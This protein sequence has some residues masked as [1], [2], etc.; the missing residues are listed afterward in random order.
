[1]QAIDGG[2]GYDVYLLDI[3]MPHLNGIDVA[4][5]V[6]ERGET[7]EILFLTTS[8]EYAVEAFGVK[9]SGYLI[10]PVQK[11]DF[12]KEMLNCIRNLAPDENPAILL[13]A[14]EGIRRM[15]IREIVMVESFNHSRVCILSDGTKVETSATLSSLYERLREYPCFF[16][17]HRAYIV[18]LDYVN[19]LTPTELMMAD[20]RRVPVSRNIYPKLKEAYMRY[21]F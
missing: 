12:E 6:R 14:K 3:I 13:K 16:L 1:M 21:A 2:G 20:G 4:R 9:A 15:H 5:K 8:R 17:P 19:G 18:N 11:A 7:A 10:K